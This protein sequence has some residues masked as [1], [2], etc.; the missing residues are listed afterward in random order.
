MRLLLALLAV[1][2]LAHIAVAQEAGTSCPAMTYENRNQTDYGPIKL[3]T[4]SGVAKD[5]EGAM[6]RQLRLV[7]F[8]CDGSPPRSH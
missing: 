4:V 5:V 6:C 8:T 2:V 3:T 1:L 7:C